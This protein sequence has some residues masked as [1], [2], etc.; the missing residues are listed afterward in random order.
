M[1]R[2]WNR[3]IW[4]VELGAGAVRSV[5]LILLGEYVLDPGLK[6]NVNKFRCNYRD[7]ARLEEAAAAVGSWTGLV[8]RLEFWNT[9]SGADQG[10]T[11]DWWMAKTRLVDI[12]PGDIGT[13]LDSPGRKMVDWTLL[14][15]DVREAWVAP[16]GGMLA[17]PD[18]RLGLTRAEI[19]TEPFAP[20]SG[21]DANQ[22]TLR[23]NRELV[24]ICLA[25]MGVSGATVPLS[26]NN[27]PAPRNL[28][29]RGNHAPTEL[30]RIL[31]A[32][33]H[34]IYPRMDGTIGIH[35]IGDGAD[36]EETADPERMLPPFEIPALDR[37]GKT[38]VYTS[39][40]HRVMATRTWTGVGAGQP[41]EWVLPQGG[42]WRVQDD[43]YGGAGVA[44]VT[45]RNRFRT[46]PEAVRE[47]YRR[48]TFR[49]VRLRPTNGAMLDLL[50]N[51]DRTTRAIELR[52]WV[53]TTADGGVTWS[54]ATG[55]SDIPTMEKFCNVVTS[56]LV[57][58]DVAAETTD[59]EYQFREL[60]AGRVALTATIEEERYYQ[61]GY[62]AEL[63]GGVRRLSEAEVV[64]ALADRDTMV[65]PA[66][67]LRLFV[68]NNEE[69]NRAELE[70]ASAQM[71]RRLL[72]GSGQSIRI[73]R[74]RGF[75]PPN[76]LS[77]RVCRISLSQER[78]LTEFRTM[79]WWVPSSARMA[80][81]ALAAAVGGK[82]GG[83]AYPGQSELRGRTLTEGSADGARPSTL[84]LPGHAP[85]T[86]WAMAAGGFS[87][88]NENWIV[89]VRALQFG[90]VGQTNVGAVA[91]TVAAT[92][93][94]TAGIDE[95][96]ARITGEVWT[97]RVGG[98]AFDRTPVT[99]LTLQNSATV[100][101]GE[102]SW[103]G[104]HLTIEAEAVGGGGTNSVATKQNLTLV[105]AATSDINIR[106]TNGGSDVLE[107]TAARTTGTDFDFKLSDL[108]GSDNGVV[109]RYNGTKAQWGWPCEV[110]QGAAKVGTANV[111]QHWFSDA[112]TVTNDEAGAAS[113]ALFNNGTASTFAGMVNI[114]KV[115]HY[116][117]STSN[118]SWTIDAGDW[119]QKAGWATGLGGGA[120]LADLWVS[121]GSSSSSYGAWLGSTGAGTQILLTLSD[122]GS[123][124]ESVQLVVYIDGDDSG[125]L[126]GTITYAAGDTNSTSLESHFAVNVFAPANWG[127]VTQEARP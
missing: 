33:H 39:A 41:L 94:A 44:A 59:P 87:G 61:V 58:G 74:T 65:V 6:P 11:P 70:A 25:A 80:E 47:Q 7:W 16:R 2:Y 48:H 109:V 4:R 46:V 73:S 118:A 34:V 113:I 108:S 101:W 103:V 52:A 17:G 84:V 123:H 14:L 72:A 63:G 71:A 92:T 90:A 126:K 125:K 119:R 55:A 43:V 111:W 105:Q 96:A 31:E 91:F 37:R 67:E 64:A 116:G 89:P 21:V 99:R 54:P 110:W 98:Y 60:A 107:F 50:V 51:R 24:E 1:S 75:G 22:Q 36:A 15:A 77:G 35:E 95:R 57:M 5:D 56:G 29:W 115:Y 26:L 85:A 106:A 28:Q 100:T 40:P 62:V 86:S 104:N 81:R 69:V 122:G 20:S 97:L 19:N 30:G 127:E 124:G 8:G 121:L 68:F 66:P 23:T 38:V 10:Q 93:P 12:D 117:P 88:T 9:N 18:A 102:V 82:G 49:A 45:V 112:F 27:W 83:Q 13:P 78:L 79:A 3:I 120:D 76:N 42:V 53:A 32:A 114:S